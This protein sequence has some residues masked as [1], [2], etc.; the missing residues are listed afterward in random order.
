MCVCV[1]VCVYLCER[2]SLCHQ[3]GVQWRDLGSPQPLPPGFKQ[4]SCLRLPSSWDY[5][6]EP[7][8]L[9]L[10]PFLKI[11]NVRFYFQILSSVPLIY[12]SVLKPVPNCFDYYGSEVSLKSRSV[13]LFKDMDSQSLFSFSFS[14]CFW[15]CQVS[16]IFIRILG[17]AFQLMQTRQ[18]R[19]PLRLHH[20]SVWRVACV[21]IVNVK[22]RQHPPKT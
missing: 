5:R 22:G 10:V 14:I 2:V 17:S 6:C 20:R 1:C 21:L 9:A 4:F 8:C 11:I 3:A 12:M 19:F 15:L 18:L 7:P 16:C 13:S